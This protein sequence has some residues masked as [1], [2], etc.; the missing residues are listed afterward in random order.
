MP[1]GQRWFDLGYS[2]ASKPILIRLF[3]H[4]V[5]LLERLIAGGRTK[6]DTYRD[7]LKA[8]AEIEGVEVPP[9][10]R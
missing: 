9:P 1:K 7:A 2:G 6:T 10:G 3:P 5:A 4:E 8:L